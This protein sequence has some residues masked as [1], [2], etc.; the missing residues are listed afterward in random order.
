MPLEAILEILKDASPGSSTNPLTSS[1]R[2]SGIKILTKEDF[3]SFSKI[4][5][6]DVTDEFL[7]FFSLL[8]SYCINSRHGDKYRGPK[9]LLPIMPRTDLLTQY[10]TFIEPKLKDQLAK[11]H[12]RTTTTLYDI[13]QKVS[14]EGK[15]LRGYTFK[16]V[17]GVITNP[18][19]EVW[20]G[21]D[22][23][24]ANGLLEVGKFL[25]YLQG[26][27]S[28][29][30][31]KLPQMDLLT[32]MDHTKRHG[33]MGGFGSR[34]ETVLGTSDPAPIFEFRELD[35]VTGLDLG[36]ALGSYE[37]KVIEYHEQYV[38]RKYGAAATAGIV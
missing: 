6:E 38:R 25:D 33:Q 2:W 23:D 32:L 16:W 12:I 26:F 14:G 17:A 9:Y 19:D 5:P 4:K 22:Q 3:K 24:I 35:K 30:K 21:K 11:H 36:D 7:G 10:K 29:T 28:S 15:A 1:F 31:K 8:A 20:T 37:Q 27:D 13:V 18:I 34:M